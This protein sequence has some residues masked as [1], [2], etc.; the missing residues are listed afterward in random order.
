MRTLKHRSAEDWILDTLIYSFAAVVFI[1]T[2]YPF[3][4]VLVV[5]FNEGIDSTRGGV[6]LWPRSFTFENYMAVFS[7]DAWTRAVLISVLRTVVGTVLGVSLTSM[8]AYAL[9]HDN[10]R[11]RKIY[12]L[13]II[14]SMY[15]NGGI[16]PY[17]VTLRALGLLNTFWVYVVPTMLNGFLVLVMVAFFRD[18]PKS[19]EESAHIDGAN[20]LQIFVRIVLPISK[21]VLATVS[22]FFGV[23]QWNAWLDSVLFVRSPD[24]RPLSFLMMEVINSSRISAMMSGMDVSMA[25]TATQVTTLSI[26]MTTIVITVVP[27]VLVYPF[28]QKHFVKG[29][30]LGSV[31]G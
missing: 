13:A 27:I 24:L 18:I 17:Y 21:P 8:V 31:K 29:V 4:Y 6:F 16:I 14:V 25:A 30:L 19:L 20:D 7:D 23:A 3:Y 15:F 5:S 1:A 12:F 22:L 28:L 2:L 9:S 11:G 26:Q 10:L